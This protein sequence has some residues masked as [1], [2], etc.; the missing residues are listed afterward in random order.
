MIVPIVLTQD[1]P[2]MPRLPSIPLENIRKKLPVEKLIRKS[3][4]DQDPAIETRS[5]IANNEFAGIV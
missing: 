4:I 5:R 3:L 2:S 1:D